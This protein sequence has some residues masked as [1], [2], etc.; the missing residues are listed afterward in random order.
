MV[1]DKGSGQRLPD[2]APQAGQRATDPGRPRVQHTGTGLRAP[3]E[4]ATANLKTWRVL[5]TDY[6]RPLRAFYDTFRAIVGFCFLKEAF[7]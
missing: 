2:A 4:R 3:I 7:A 6:R 5:H 1:T